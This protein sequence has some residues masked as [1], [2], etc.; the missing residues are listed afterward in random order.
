MAD[1]PAMQD[2]EIAAGALFAEIG[3]RDVAEDGAHETELLRSYVEG[4]RAWVAEEAG[5]VCGYALADVLDGQG[6][7]EQVTVHPD[8]GR[9]GI[10]SQII[11]VVADWA[12]AQ[13]YRSLT[14]LTFDEVAWNGPYYGR[15]GFVDVPDPE[16]G[17]ELAALR[18]HE[19]DL[20]LDTSIRGAMVLS[21]A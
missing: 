20:G 14:L 15:L 5:D 16:M 18:A 19:A 7:L 12:R 2:I 8:Y 3:M 9:R 4:G 10:G 21:L 13:G 1:I 6:H 17:P 11:D